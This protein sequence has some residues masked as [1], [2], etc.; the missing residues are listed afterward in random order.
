MSTP[1]EYESAALSHVTSGFGFLCVS[2]LE[3]QVE[4]TF[5]GSVKGRSFIKA[6]AEAPAAELRDLIPRLKKK[7]GQDF[8]IPRFRADV[9]EAQ[10]QLAA[11]GSR[12]LILNAATG[13]PKPCVANAIIVMQNLPIRYNEFASR[14][15]VSGTLPWN[16][17]GS[18]EWKDHRDIKAAEWCQHQGVGIPKSIAAEAVDVIA[19]EHKFHP[20]R[21]Y[22]DPLVWD[23]KCRLRKWLTTY[24][25]CDD[26]ELAEEM[27]VRWLISGVARIYRPGCQCDYTLVTEGVQGIRKSSAMRALA[28]PWF[29]DTVR[30]IDKGH[31]AAIQ[32]Q[33]QWIVEIKELAAF[34]H[35]KWEQ[36][37]SWLDTRID[38][39]RS[40][41][42]RRAETHPRQNIFSASTNKRQWNEDDTGAR[43]FWPIW[44]R[45]CDEVRLKEDRNQLW[46]EAKRYFD[47]GERW[48]LPPEMEAEVTKEQAKRRVSDPWMGVIKRWCSAPHSKHAGVG[49]ESDRRMVYVA[50]V[51]EHCLSMPPGQWRQSEGNRVESILRGL[52]YERT[53]E[54]VYGR[55]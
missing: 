15:E 38:H 32:L 23:G 31:E 53:E 4:D 24:M 3:G 49:I 30:D 36:V 40:P 54:G 39:F 26:T 10:A 51:L 35:S 8:S 47:T 6:A 46:A 37:K 12:G 41:Y 29:T 16:D 34:R 7:W 48:Y 33:G 21:E 25:G 28:D 9:K 55:E 42:D 13:T 43:R 17:D 27:G 45:K 1:N 18:A 50:E 22:L 14:I 2:V 11:N 44:A 5:P 20:V 19:R 52:G